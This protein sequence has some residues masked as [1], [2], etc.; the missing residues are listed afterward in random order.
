MVLSVWHRGAIG[1]APSCHSMGREEDRSSHINAN[2]GSRVVRGGGGGEWAAHRGRACG[3]RHVGGGGVGGCRGGSSV[4]LGSAVTLRAV[5]RSGP[6][7]RPGSCRRV[8]RRGSLVVLGPGASGLESVELGVDLRARH[9]GP[10]RGSCGAGGVA[11]GLLGASGAA[12]GQ[13]LVGGGALLVGDLGR[14]DQG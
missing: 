2:E 7:S 10:A 14:L 13:E 4:A 8:V 12:G 3:R 11:G 5:P 9:P 6:G 1:L